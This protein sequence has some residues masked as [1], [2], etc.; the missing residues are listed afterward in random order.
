MKKILIIVILV[1]LLILLGVWGYL[2]L[3]GAPERL[4]DT[5]A[6]FGAENVSNNDSATTPTSSA[7]NQP[8]LPR[9]LVGAPLVQ[10]SD[11]PVAGAVLF[12]RDNSSFIRYMERG[13]AHIFEV[14]LETGAVSQ[15]TNTT[16]VRTTHAQWSPHGTRVILTTEVSPTE[17][18]MSVGTLQR[19]DNGA[20]VLE[21]EALP[22]GTSSAVFTES[23]DVVYYTITTPSGSL[24]FVYDLKTGT[25][26][27][28]ADL[29]FEDSVALTDAARSFFLTKP[30]SAFPGYLYE[31]QGQL[32]N[33]V[34][35]G[36]GLT[37]EIVSGGFAISTSTQD[38]L[39]SG[40]IRF[41]GSYVTPVAVA[42]LPEKCADAEDALWCAAPLFLPSGTYPDMWYQGAVSFDDELWRIDRTNGVAALLMDL[43][44]EA[45]KTID[46]IDLLVYENGS[47]V[48]FTDKTTGLLWLAKPEV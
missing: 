7:E 6:N 22:P 1:V 25:T 15:I 21:M 5:F 36:Q 28:R 34:A 19:N 38:G 20:T 31:Q 23:G 10:V 13:T 11:Q 41:D 14:D 24:F 2:L 48:L 27:E 32:L 8:A 17:S 44:D 26:E 37:A 45:G 16:V 4:S 9:V 18:V 33:R 42:T 35:T 43:S 47:R 12:S 3:Y 30:T 29:P 39:S 40:I 46:A